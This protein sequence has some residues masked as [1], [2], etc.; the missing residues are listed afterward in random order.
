MKN[1][2]SILLFAVISYSLKYLCL[3]TVQIVTINGKF[4]NVCERT[5]S[6][7]YENDT[8]LID[9]CFTI[10]AKN[11]ILMKQN[12]TRLKNK[13]LREIMSIDR[14]KLR[15]KD[16]F[17]VYASSSEL[18]GVSKLQEKQYLAKQQTSKVLIYNMSAKFRFKRVN[19][20][21]RRAGIRSKMISP[22]GSTG[23]RY[24]DVL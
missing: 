6:V 5:F 16:C 24:K 9:V 7:V 19:P 8:V 11:L 12:G 21:F 13:T 23:I 22:Q 17:E 15:S 1:T 20:T 3:S 10:L 18:N 14:E 2:D 4:R